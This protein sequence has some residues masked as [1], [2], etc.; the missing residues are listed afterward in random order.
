MVLEKLAGLCGMSADKHLSSSYTLFDKGGRGKRRSQW[1]AVGKGEV[2]DNELMQLHSTIQIV[3]TTYISFL[4]L[5][6]SLWP[7]LS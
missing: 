3:G 4:N 7:L 2:V 5:N 1:R 6:L